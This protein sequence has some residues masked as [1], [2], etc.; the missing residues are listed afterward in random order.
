MI[1]EDLLGAEGERALGRLMK[2]LVRH[3]REVVE[4]LGPGPVAP[5][6]NR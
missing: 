2:L 3:Q 1:A 6:F 5:R 4:A